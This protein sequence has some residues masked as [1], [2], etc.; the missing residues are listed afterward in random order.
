VWEKA[1]AYLRQAGLRALARAVNR[2]A[3]AHLEQALGALRRLPETREATELT[4]DIRIDLRNALLPLAEWARMGEHL[5]EAEG[6]ARALGDQHRLGRIATFMVVQCLVTGD[7]DE[8]LRF[9]QEALTIARTLG[10][11]SIEVAATTF[12]GR[13]HAARGEFSDAGTPFERNVALEA[14]LRYERFG[15]SNIQSALSGACLADVL[16]QLGRFD[17]A[18]GHAEAAVRI[19]EAVDN[20]FTLF[21][22]LIDL[23]LAHLRR[24]DLPRVRPASS[25]A[26]SSSAERGRSSSGHRSSPRPSAPTTPSPA[27]PTRRS[28]WSRAPWRSSAVARIIKGR[29]SFFCAR[30]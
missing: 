22:G 27:V 30:G 4:I 6:L 24:G 21:Q 5:H 25:S 12:L 18:V 9:G 2:E 1:V 29:R 3:I 19:A 8:A 17:E 10:E 11:R 16:S 20:P 26:A 13:T 14:D 7:Y 28:R 23:G 15:T